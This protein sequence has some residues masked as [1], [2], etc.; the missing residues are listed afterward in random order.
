MCVVIRR[1][2]SS[3]GKTMGWMIGSCLVDRKSDTQCEC[4]GMVSMFAELLARMCAP[5]ADNR[6][7]AIDVMNELA[8]QYVGRP[9]FVFVLKTDSQMPAVTGWL[10]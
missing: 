6:P 2:L 3:N 4:A 1:V 10:S 8:L 5:Q 7:T 9:S